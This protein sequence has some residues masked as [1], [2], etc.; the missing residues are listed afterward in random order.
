M[1][2]SSAPILGFNYEVFFKHKNLKVTISVHW[3][4]IDLMK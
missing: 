3:F 2:K 4:S 1:K